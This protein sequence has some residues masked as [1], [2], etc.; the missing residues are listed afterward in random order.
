[1]AQSSKISLLEE[2]P[3]LKKTIELY[4]IY[5]TFSTLF[6]K[7]DK[8]TIGQTTEKYIIQTIELLLEASYATKETKR[9]IIL[10]ANN[11]FEALKIFIRLL[12]ELNVIDDKKYI[13]LQTRIQEIGKMF[14]GWLKSLPQ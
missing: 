14:G 10:S 2:V 8:Y 11:K 5:Y 7:K 1:L 6:P 3:I 12:K 13:L 9:R 4:K